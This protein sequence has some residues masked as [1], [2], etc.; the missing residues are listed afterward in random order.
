VTVA[1]GVRGDREKIGERDACRKPDRIVGTAAL[2]D[3]LVAL[4][5]V[6]EVEVTARST[7]QRVI[8]RTAGDRIIELGCVDKRDS[9]GALN[10][11]QAGICNGD[12]HGTRP[13]VG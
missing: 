3:E 12:Q 7:L 11:I 4:I 5:L 2:D 9:Q 13:D 10:V 8:A 6:D 1:V